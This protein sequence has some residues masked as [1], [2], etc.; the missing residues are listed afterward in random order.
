MG[1]PGLVQRLICPGNA[2]WPDTMELGSVSF[3]D[4]TRGFGRIRTDRYPEGV[5][6]HYTQVTEPARILVPHE[7]VHFE[8]GESPKG[9][10]AKAVARIS[11]RLQGQI[12]RYSQGA[13]YIAE[14]EGGKTWFFH[15][16]DVLGEGFKRIEAGQLVEFSP[17][18]GEERQAKEVV[19]SDTRPPLERFARM[20]GP[21]MWAQLAA[22]AQPEPWDYPE[23][24]T[25]DH[26]VLRSYLRHTFGR[27]QEE[28]KIAVHAP[29]EGPARAAFNTGLLTPGGEE[30]FAF[31]VPNQHQMVGYL[32]APAWRFHHFGPESD[33]WMRFFPERPPLAQYV[34]DPAA[35]IYDPQ[36]RLVPDFGHI[37]AERLRRFPAFFRELA[38]AEQAASLR[39]ALHRA[40]RAVQ[41][42]YRQAVPQYYQGQIQLLLPLCLRQPAQPDLAL[43]I[44][45][46]EAVYRAHTVLP[47]H[48]AYQNARLLAPPEPA[49]LLQALHQP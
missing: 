24:P 2:K 33:H 25:G 44:A 22:L 35:L 15:H 49:W 27:L 26:P 30:I 1:W 28:D 29:A 46:D 48:W 11:P 32:R 42:N 18:E 31:F 16:R 43:V 20:G 38:P 13:G 4:I 34:T 40:S 5:F 3:F 19:L 9:P 23:R 7:L 47:L 6:V 14:T 10:Q 21:E 39:A 37:L 8:L 12:I 36:R 45:P 17:F 41:R